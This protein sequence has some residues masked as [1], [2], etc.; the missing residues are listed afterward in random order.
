M[1]KIPPLIKHG[2]HNVEIRRT[3]NHHA[4]QYWCLD[5]NKHVSWLSKQEAQKALEEN[6]IKEDIK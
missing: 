6:L 4:A 3:S 5:C 1:A 2:A